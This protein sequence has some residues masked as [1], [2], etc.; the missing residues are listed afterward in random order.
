MTELTEKQHLLLDI[1]NN[2]IEID[3]MINTV[4]KS[5]KN[6]LEEINKHPPTD[7][8]KDYDDLYNIFLLYNIKLYENLKQK[9]IKKVLRLL[10]LIKATRNKIF[11]I[12]EELDLNSNEYLR[13]SNILKKDYESDEKLRETILRIMSC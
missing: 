1:L 9:D 10:D 13:C 8:N 11:E 2:E 4:K 3:K 7:T 6:I 12:G 5:H